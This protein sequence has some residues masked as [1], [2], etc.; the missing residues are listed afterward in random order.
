[1]TKRVQIYEVGP[2]DGLQSEVKVLSVSQRVKMIEDL[3]RAGLHDIE[4]GS[5]VRSDWVPQLAHTDRVVKALRKKSQNASARFWAFVPNRRGLEAAVECG[6][7]GVALFYSVSDRFSRSNVNRSKAQLWRELAPLMGQAKKI[8]M[9]F[10]VYLSTCFHCPYEGWIAAK[11]VVDDVSQLF[12]HGAPLVAISDTTGRANPHM[13]ETLAKQLIKRFSPNQFAFHLHNTQGM[14][15]ANIH[16]LLQMGFRRFDGS[17]A[18]IGGCPYAPGATGNVATEDIVAMVQGWGAAQDIR[19]PR[20]IE[21]G[22]RM[23]RLMGRS[24]PGAML[25]AGMIRSK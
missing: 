1:M 16:A 24:L 23:E 13:V 20:M 8:K 9:P 17:V 19:V 7:D 15:L 4:V 25:R 12:D 2:R 22:R 21:V 14:A 11:R 5:F 10:R 18:G 6:V 3:I